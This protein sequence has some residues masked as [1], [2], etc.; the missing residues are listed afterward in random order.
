MLVEDRRH[1]GN[2]F[3]EITFRKGFSV[4]S[5]LLFQ[6]L[7]SLHAQKTLHWE[8]NEQAR[9]LLHLLLLLKFMN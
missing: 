9:N 8:K 5:T 2:L 6:K 1:D 7:H 4:F 3:P